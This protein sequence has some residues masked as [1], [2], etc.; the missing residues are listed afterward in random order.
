[1]P[2]IRQALISRFV[3]FICKLASSR[4]E[5]L[6]RTFD[7]LK[8]DC[9]STTGANI[10]NIRLESQTG[11]SEQL[12]AKC[13]SELKFHPVPPEEEWRI[14]LVKDLMSMRENGIHVDT[15]NKDELITML[16]YLCT[17]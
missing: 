3:G 15:M 10:R 7:V 2:H 5:V 13:V 4:K 1:M 6:R 17:T 9:R 11:L 16:E 8:G 12:S 14:D